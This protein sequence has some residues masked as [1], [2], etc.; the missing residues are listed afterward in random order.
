MT[1]VQIHDSD[2]DAFDEVFLRKATV[3]P[4]VRAAARDTLN[5]MAQSQ[6]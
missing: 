1:T 5:P 2:Q 6:V 3:D 4:Q